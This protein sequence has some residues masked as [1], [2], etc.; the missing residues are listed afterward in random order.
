MA[1]ALSLTPC[2]P[3]GKVETSQTG[4][5]VGPLN[6]DA[7][8]FQAWQL[9]ALDARPPSTRLLSTGPFR[10]LISADR[11]RG[12]MTL[13][14]RRPTEGETRDA[15]GRVRSELEGHQ[16]GL[17]VEYNATA[18]PEVGA[19]LEATGMRPERSDP[20]MACRPARFQP[21]AA[22]DVTQRRLT[23][24]SYPADLEAFQ[25][26]RWTNGG[27]VRRPIPPIEQLRK[28][29][30]S[31]TSVFLLAWVDG[32]RCGTGVL[33]ALKG[34]AEIVGV[35]TRVDKRRRGVA[36]AV[37]SKLVA[38]HFGAGGDFAFLNAANDMAVRVYQRLG[39]TWFGTNTVYTGR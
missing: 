36:A 38:D 4:A 32:E 22:L 12:W 9:D 29:L 6:D 31:E 25:T 23:P 11:S 27:D 16:V 7:G 10:A 37:T 24:A 8:R 33:H 26:I 15:V 20:L 13:V 28:E 19:F 5:T 18:Y 30:A 17:E 2:Q 3:T 35:V 39:F 14:E 1:S 21:V 34:A